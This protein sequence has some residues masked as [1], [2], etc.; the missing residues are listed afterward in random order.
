M[1]YISHYMLMDVVRTANPNMVCIFSHQA[2]HAYKSKYGTV[3]GPYSKE[4][5]AKFLEVAKEVNENAKAKVCMNKYT[6]WDHFVMDSWTLSAYTSSC[7][8]TC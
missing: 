7:I 3:P 1:Y 5:A 8:Y 6:N 4:D 2:L